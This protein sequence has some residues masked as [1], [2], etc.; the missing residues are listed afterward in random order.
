[1][2][3]KAAPSEVKFGVHLSGSGDPSAEA[4]LAERLGFDIVVV[5]QGRSSWS[6][7]PAMSF[8]AYAIWS[9]R[10]DQSASAS[11]RSRSALDTTVMLEADIASAANSGRSISPNAGY[12]TPAAT[13]IAIRL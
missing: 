3:V 11:R 1:M 12:S 8:R 7:S 6:A 9:H 2:R 4:A 13:G 5:D 10:G